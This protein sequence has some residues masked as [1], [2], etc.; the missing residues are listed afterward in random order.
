MQYLDD[1]LAAQNA[2][3]RPDGAR[4]ND[5]AHEH[6]SEP[7]GAPPADDEPR[8]P[9]L[10]DADAPADDHDTVV[11]DRAPADAPEADDA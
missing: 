6:T 10:D 7:W 5:A 9:F 11:I 4:S 1:I 3:A 8:D 2:T